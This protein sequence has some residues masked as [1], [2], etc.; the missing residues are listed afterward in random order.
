MVNGAAITGETDLDHNDRIVVGST[1]IW[2][3]QVKSLFEVS[4]LF[5]LQPRRLFFVRFEG[6]SILPKILKLDFFPL[7]LDF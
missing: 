4:T 3:F 2:I 7:K 5:C 1:H 6:N